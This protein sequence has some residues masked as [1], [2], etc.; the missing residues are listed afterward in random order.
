M[1][2]SKIFSNLTSGDVRRMV[3]A[4]IY[5]IFMVALVVLLVSAFTLNPAAVSVEQLNTI[6]TAGV[7]IIVIYVA[8]ILMNMFIKKNKY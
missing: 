1:H 8:K 6:K 4:A 3:S 7:V 2:L 5:I